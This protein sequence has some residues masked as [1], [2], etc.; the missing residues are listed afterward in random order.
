MKKFIFT[1]NPLQNLE[2]IPVLS[3][4]VADSQSA[5]ELIPE[6]GVFPQG[7]V[8][9]FFNMESTFKKP[10]IRLNIETDNNTISEFLPITMAGKVDIIKKFPKNIKRI[11]LFPTHEQSK[12]KIDGVTI[13][14]LSHRERIYLML[15]RVLYAKIKQK[16]EIKWKEI[17]SNLYQSYINVSPKIIYRGQDKKIKRK[18]E[19]IKKEVKWEGYIDNIS[20]DLITG[21]IID[22]ESPGNPLTLDFYINDIYAGSVIADNERLDIASVKGVINCGFIFQIPGTFKKGIF[23]FAIYISGTNQKVLDTPKVYLDFVEKIEALNRL[24]SLIKLEE[25]KENIT[26]QENLYLKWLRGSFIPQVISTIRDA[27][28][29]PT[30]TIT[31]KNDRI[32]ESFSNP[33]KIVDV[34]IPV[35]RSKDETIACIESVL[36]AK[37]DIPYEVIVINDCS[38][39]K[40]I[41]DYLRKLSNE[42]KI[43]LIENP[44]NLGFVKSVNIG[45]MLHENRD[46]ILLNSDTI[47]PDYWIDRLYK[48]AYSSPVIGTVTPFS[49]KA[50]ICSFPV[51]CKDNEMLLNYSVK[52]LDRIFKKVNNGYIEEIPTAVGF[53]MYIKRECLKE[54]GLFD[55]EKWGTGYG[56]ENEFCLKASDLGWRHVVACDLFV[57]HHGSLSFRAEK[58]ERIKNNLEIL[59]NLY[60][61]YPQKISRFIKSDPLRKHRNRVQ[62]EMLKETYSSNKFA[63]FI[64]HPF[65]G[66]SL[67]YMN[68]ISGLL[69]KDGYAVLYLFP[70]S[71]YEWEI[72]VYN[73]NFF[74]FTY[75]AEDDS[76]I[77]ALIDDLKSLN[78]E[79]I[80]FN[81]TIGLPKIVWTLPDKLDIPYYFTIHD[82]FVICPRVNLIDKKGFYC[83]E[84]S[85]ERCEICVK[86]S[87]VHYGAEVLFK[88]LGEEVSRWRDFHYEKLK[89]ARLIFSPSKDAYH[90]IK[91]YFN[92]ENIVV[93]PHPEKRTLIKLR[94][95]K[96]IEKIN[97]AVI[98]AIG[99][100]KGYEVL[101]EC[102]KDALRRKLLINYIVIGYT[103]DDKRLERFKN[104]TITGRYRDFWEL[105]RFTEIYDT[106]VALF[107]SICPETFSYT[108]SEAFELGLY[109]VSFDIGAIAERIK[110]TGFGK[111]LP[112]DT[113]PSEINNILISEVKRI[114]NN[115][116]NIM[117]IYSGVEYKNIGEYYG[118]DYSF[119]I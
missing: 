4:W 16:K 101:Y 37:S 104:I 91:K 82:Y 118:N 83:G 39:E 22:S 102:A 43:T 44:I 109:P 21:W 73:D 75:K 63:L 116:N 86:D 18:T 119:G 14:E 90:R 55:E 112:I 38:P 3:S 1:L 108:L 41:T 66:G 29:S 11:L 114:F 36:S 67:K 115:Q 65:E 24:S 88:E 99:E 105:K 98:G 5:F 100:H 77:D 42:R 53:C 35:Y 87:G 97:V 26:P 15:K 117:E 80:H 10:L 57:Q 60:P 45:M 111:V 28:N 30:F 81:H 25:K 6:K 9:I 84:P 32:L 56:E 49:N 12:I 13:Y 27:K 34:I 31:L 61:E 46:V 58:D 107:L 94:K 51:F 92:L 59:N 93:K 89:K 50:T 70:H 72:R 23:E 17:F 64:N 69:A 103:L 96:A 48:A 113:E 40:E 76:I 52:D 8:R 79:F 47:V 110:E 7:W 2:R 33:V 95:V 71:Y 74:N 78:P 62:I 68:D 19:Q 54:V 85:V 106:S 20:S